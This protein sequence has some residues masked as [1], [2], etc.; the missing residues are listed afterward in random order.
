VRR[1]EL[2][3]ERML[4]NAGGCA[5]DVECC[6]LGRLRA[7]LERVVGVLRGASRGA[8][9]RAGNSIGAAGAASLAPSL[10][11]MKKLTFLGLGCKLRAS[12]QQRCAWMLANAGCAWIMLR[13]VGWGG[14]A[15]GCSRWWGFCE[16]RVE[17]R[18][19]CVQAIGSEQLGQLRWHRVSAG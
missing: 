17:G 4:S 16:G 5:D 10:E 8:E 19:R 9:V 15:R 13:A 7:G 3:C 14:C 11:R 12:A 1:R 2:R 6:G 18:P